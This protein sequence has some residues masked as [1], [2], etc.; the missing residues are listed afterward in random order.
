LHGKIELLGEELDRM[1]VLCCL[2]VAIQSLLPIASLL[3]VSYGGEEVSM[4]PFER[5]KIN[6][7][8]PIKTRPEHYI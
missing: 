4:D 2:F 5:S 1:E 6:L 3:A 7:K 8:T